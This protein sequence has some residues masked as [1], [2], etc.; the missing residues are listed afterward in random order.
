MRYSKRV[1]K[2]VV[3]AG[4]ALALIATLFNTTARSAHAAS[5]V[6]VNDDDT[7][8]PF[9][10]DDAMDINPQSCTR[11]LHLSF[12]LQS[13]NWTDTDNNITNVGWSKGNGD[14]GCFQDGGEQ[15]ELL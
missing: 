2:S 5:P 8:V 11:E 9:S 10:V 4:T 12:N 6:Q 13:G 14:T 7:G 15:G 3:Q 1:M